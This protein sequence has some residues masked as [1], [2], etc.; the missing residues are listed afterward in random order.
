MKMSSIARS[1][2][3]TAFAVMI[4]APLIAQ[5]RVPR[6]EPDTVT[7]ETVFD[8]SRDDARIVA[9]LDAVRKRNEAMRTGDL[10]TVRKYMPPNMVVN[11]PINRIVDGRN[12]LARL[13]FTRS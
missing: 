1:V 6:S 11:A 7:A 10:V 8:P 12:V 4:G 5:E 9:V 3:V 13:F 2:M